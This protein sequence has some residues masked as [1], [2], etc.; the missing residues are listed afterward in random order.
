M[1]FDCNVSHL[2]REAKIL[3]T[4]YARKFKDQKDSMI[5]ATDNTGIIQTT[6][7]PLGCTAT[8]VFDHKALLKSG[9]RRMRCWPYETAKLITTCVENSADDTRSFVL[10]VEYEKYNYSVVYPS[11]GKLPNHLLQSFVEYESKMLPLFINDE[12]DA[13]AKEVE[14]LSKQDILYE[15]S[16]QE[17]YRLWMAREQI[18]SNFPAAFPKLVLAVPYQEPCAVAI[19]HKLIQD[20]IADIDPM[21]YLEFLSYNHAD[22]KVREMSITQLN[23]LNDHQLEGYVLQMVQTLKFELYHDSALARFLLQRGL[24]STHIIGHILF[25]HLKSEMFS[26]IV[27]ERHGLILEEYL[28]TCGS[29]RRELVKQ[30]AV[31]EQLL[32][33][34]MKIKKVKKAD[35]VKVLHE[36]LKQFKHPPKFKLPLSPRLEVKG[37]IVNKCKVMDSAKLPI[38]LA[39]E[40]CD[41]TSSLPILVIF[42]AGDDLRQDLLTLQ[43][44]RILDKTWRHH[45]LDLHMQPYGCVCT[46]FMTGMIEVVLNS[47]TMYDFIVQLLTNSQCQYYKSARRCHCCPLCRSINVLAQ[48]AKPYCQG[49]AHGARQFCLVMCRLL[50]GHLCIGYWR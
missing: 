7:V 1:T 24:R 15:L 19:F 13:N 27:R 34:A 11:K 25:W 20:P 40:N 42:K 31:V 14:R 37:I 45:G 21:T 39:F 38:W 29:H 35:Q 43:V 47:D 2:P 8:A 30:N 4:L 3:C 48:E 18:V 28:K 10:T 50:R 36:E 41:T 9:K 12:A 17:K 5:F 32:T 46:G 44:L 16:E 49:L 22:T 6:D 33:I 26:P 23:E